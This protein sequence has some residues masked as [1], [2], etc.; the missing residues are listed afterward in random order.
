MLD[1]I[2]Y[3]VK[4]TNAQ[5]PSLAQYIRAAQAILASKD[6]LQQGIKDYFDKEENKKIALRNK[7][8]ET[9]TKDIEDALDSI[10]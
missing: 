7:L 1:D 4:A 9:V 8:V 5:L 2:Q 3:A 10:V 6:N